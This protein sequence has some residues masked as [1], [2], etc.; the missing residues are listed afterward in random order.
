MARRDKVMNVLSSEMCAATD[1]ANKELSEINKNIKFM[2]DGLL[3]LRN[4][5]TELQ[6][7]FDLK[8]LNEN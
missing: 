2:K 5:N 7:L 6:E 4:R 3:E 1:R 8:D